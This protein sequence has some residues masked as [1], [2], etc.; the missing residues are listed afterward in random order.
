VRDPLERDVVVRE[1]DAWARPDRQGGTRVAMQT[2]GRHAALMAAAWVAAACVDPTRESE[3]ELASVRGS[4]FCDGTAATPLLTQVSTD[5]INKVTGVAQWNRP[6]AVA[7]NGDLYMVAN[8]TVGTKMRFVVIKYAAATSRSDYLRKPDGTYLQYAS[9]DPD[10][11]GHNLLSIA[12]D[13]HGFVHVVGGFH[14]QST[15]PYYWRSTFTTGQAFKPKGFAAKWGSANIPSP[16][17]YSS[18]H[19]Y[20]IIAGLGGDVYLVMRTI[21]KKDTNTRAMPL[22]R[23]N[24]ATNK[25][26]V[27]AVVAAQTGFTVYPTDVWSDGQNLHMAYEWMDG[28]AGG[29]RH[30]ASY[31]KYS[32][33]TG[34]FSKASGATVTVPV[35]IT[36]SDVFDD[37]RP[38]EALDQISEQVALYSGTM[39][40]KGRVKGG[41]VQILLRRRDALNRRINLKQF[42]YAGRWIEETV[43]DAD[44]LWAGTG[45]YLSKMLG[46]TDNGAMTR[47]LYGKANYAAGY[48]PWSNGITEIDALIQEKGGTCGPAWSVAQSIGKGAPFAVRSGGYDNVYLND[49]ANQV[50]KVTR[51]Q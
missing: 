4:A 31:V 13:G 26:S 49:F 37:L 42:R 44:R 23:W 9:D 34:K 14:N 21:K 2:I 11:E 35:G 43:V 38:G 45:W 16:S 12:I 5:P 17:G 50:L 40:G 46:F 30:K 33:A 51:L 47:V 22:W 19:T 1:A 41:E 15:S 20:P 25:W 3:S 48:N 18:M 39:G 29:I 28:A 32:P 7:S 36:G 10:N 27:V 6:L 24:N 8:V